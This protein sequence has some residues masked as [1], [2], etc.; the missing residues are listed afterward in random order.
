MKP[1]A[2][3]MCKVIKIDRITHLTL[4][5]LIGFILMLPYGNINASEIK[6]K[7]NL[8]ILGDSL[9]AGYGINI[10]KNWTD[11]LQSKLDKKSLN[12]KIINAS[13]SGDTTANGLNRLN[14][15][16]K[17]FQPSRVLI[18]L[19][20]NDGLRGLPLKHIKKNLELIVQASLAYQAEV[21]LM[22]IIIPPNYGKKYTD[23][24]NQIYHDLAEQ[25][26]LS[27][28]PFLLTD[29][30]TTPGLMQADGL[31]PNEKAHHH[32]YQHHQNRRPNRRHSHCHQRCCSCR[33]HRC[34]SS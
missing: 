17:Q 29:V 3:T 16:L 19:G 21:I 8:L 12:I 31:H 15:A 22:E 24:F 9:S 30:A 13:I 14:Q 5:S 23:A 26:S 7:N 25:Y 20:A 1:Q 2:Q 10:G 32:P 6:G 34:Y 18:E 27:L 11:R 28:I 33:K 4:L